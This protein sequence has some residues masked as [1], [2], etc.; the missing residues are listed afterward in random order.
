MQHL[1]NCSKTGRCELFFANPKAIWDISK[2]PNLKDLSKTS[3]KKI[4]R[5]HKNDF[6]VIMQRF[7]SG[8]VVYLR[9]LLYYNLPCSKVLSTA[10]C[11]FA[12]H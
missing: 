10:H 3:T 5:E 2:L 12:V 9:K 7:S 1:K 11:F 6:S 8:G 4:P